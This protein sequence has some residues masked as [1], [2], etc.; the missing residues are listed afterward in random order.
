MWNNEFRHFEKN[1]SFDQQ[2]GPTEEI[3]EKLLDPISVF[4]EIFPKLNI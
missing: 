2:I 3:N 4:Q 1:Y